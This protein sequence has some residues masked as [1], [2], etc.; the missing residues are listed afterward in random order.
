MTRKFL[1]HE[2]SKVVLVVVALCGYSLR[3]SKKT[4][5]EER[6]CQEQ[7]VAQAQQCDALI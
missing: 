5:V 1:I 4:L 2:M 6:H 7:F 3:M